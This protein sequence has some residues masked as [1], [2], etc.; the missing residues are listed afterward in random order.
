MRQVE[1]ATNHGLDKYIFM[2]AGEI[3]DVIDANVGAFRGHGGDWEGDTVSSFRSKAAVGDNSLVEES[4]RFLAEI[5][6][7]VP[8]SRGWR[9]VD[10]VVGAVPNVPAFLAGHPQCMRRRERAARD[11]APLAIY[12]DLT[13]SGGIDASDV[14]RRGVVLLALCR[15]LVEH[16]AVELW[17][18][19]SLGGWSRG[20]SGTVAWRIDTTPLDL[21]RAAYHIGATAMSRLFGY[22]LNQSLNRTGGAWPFNNYD[23]HVRTA[24]ERLRRIMDHGGDLLYIPG[25]YLTDPMTRDPIGWLKRTM[26]QYVKQ[27]D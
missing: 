22:K 15:M 4:E 7:Q 6:D 21:A 3:P 14:A 27:E 1:Q 8:M 13:S 25:I 20:G 2:D 23:L 26:Q 10:D 18:G 11:N 5:E 12:M 19:A 24:E 16:R 9:N 17:V